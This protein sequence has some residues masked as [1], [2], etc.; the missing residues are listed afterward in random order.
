MTNSTTYTK[1]Q[2]WKC[3]LQ[4]NPA[5]YIQYRGQAQVMS[6]DE[7]NQAILTTCLEEKIKVI[8]CADHGKVDAI[9]SLKLVLSPHNIIVFPGFE[10]A[11]SEKI[12]FVCLYDENKTAQELERILGQLDLLDPT[13]GIQP[14]RL[15]AIALIDKVNEQGGFIYA[16]HCINDD[17]LLKRRMNHVWLHQGLVAAQISS[18]IED[19]KGVADDFYRKAIL[20]K[21][22][23]YQ[24][25]L[26]MAV[27][28][29]ADVAEP[30]Q[31]REPRSTCFIKMTTPNFASFKQAFLDPSSR[32]RLHSDMPEN[33]A[34][35]IERIQFID[36]YLDGVDIEISEHLNAI[37]G[38]RGTGKSTL[39]ECIRYALDKQPFKGG[40]A[41][42]Q[43]KKIIAENL[44][45][46]KGL[47]K[48]TVRSYTMNGRRFTIS[49]KYGEQPIVTDE[50][51]L[52]T[53]FHPADLL[54][55]LELYGQNEIYEM[56]RDEAQRTLLIKRVVSDDNP[57]ESID[58]LKVKIQSNR[59]KIV[60]QLTKK[61]MIEVEVEQ[62]PHLLE[63]A[64]QFADLGLEEKLKVI[65]TL[66]R[67]K[68]LIQTV[69]QEIQ[70]FSTLSEIII[71]NLPDATFLNESVIANLP[72]ADELKKL[73][74]ILEALKKTG[75]KTSQQIT[76][77]ITKTANSYQPIKR[78]LEAKIKQQEDELE[79]AFKKI[80]ANKG[81]SG[82]ELGIEYKDIL[83]KIERIKPK[84]QQLASRQRVITELYQN[85]ISLHGELNEE[86]T[87]R[88]SKT[89]KGIKKLNKKLQNN[90]KLSLRS[91]SN[92]Q[93]IIDFLLQ[94]HLENIGVGRLS[95]VST[96]DFTVVSLAQTIRNGHDALLGANWSITPTIANALVKMTEQQLLLLEEVMVN[97]EMVIE[98]NINHTGEPNYKE[99]D[100]LS[101]GQQCT[102]ILHLL[103]L[104]NQDPLILD[105][106]EDN[107]DNAFIADR[108]VTQLRKSKTARQFIFATHNANIP[109][110]GDAEWIGVIR[111][112]DGKGEISS[113]QQ[114]AI[115]V[116]EVQRL[117]ADILEGGEVAFDQ[118]R[119]KYGFDKKSL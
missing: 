11:S 65:P 97:D 70:Q 92:R 105:Q 71:D 77:A 5:S 78:S 35:A 110:F 95:W 47:I 94:C 1:A 41:D 84:Q 115:D 73:R 2:Y 80:P 38:G 39:L 52:A 40:S 32:I 48:L 117:A 21:L 9:E 50:S 54:P 107:L 37:I 68:L 88:S 93:D 86:I 81:K 57:S 34:S 4:V 62:L 22:T 28:N 91:E 30:E 3:A 13:D 20:N 7:Y 60:E 85:R 23:D 108:I 75:E 114:G 82:K 64:K 19:L 90:V 74:S 27:I 116:P 113:S 33:H 118:R 25:K 66:A 55:N 17:G 111:V 53:Q 31:L 102:A 101:T 104:D 44:G 103:L 6:E 58:S 67:E 14:S 29:A 49:R 12:H 98:L 24:R 15:S 72:H 56:V 46:D 61:S 99:V 76:E 42:A 36:G 112:N 18:S 83:T 45:K 106:P 43:H 89:K 96:H 59:E 16:A 26:P 79:T 51:G 69:D 87:L 8:G 109:V 63:R 100:S 119:K 10:I